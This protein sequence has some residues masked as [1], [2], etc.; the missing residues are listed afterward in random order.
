MAW[1]Q[2]PNFG[3]VHTAVDAAAPFAVGGGNKVLSFGGGAMYENAQ[4]ATDA[5]IK[6]Q[7]VNRV[8][9][10]N[11]PVNVSQPGVALRDSSGNMYILQFYLHPRGP[12]V[13]KGIIF[14]IFRYE[15]SSDTF[16]SILAFAEFVI[17]FSAVSGDLTDVIDTLYEIEFR[18]ESDS[19]SI[20]VDGGAV[21]GVTDSTYSGPF[22]PA[23]V[24]GIIIQSSLIVGFNNQIDNFA[25][26]SL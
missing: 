26:R 20:L 12:N 25:F 21:S 8:P 11:A 10:G 24:N 6:F 9:A 2:D 19:L 22:N 15:Q 17:E 3:G 23:L 16:T 14:S 5:S 1:V 18:K 4:S 13:N 7:L